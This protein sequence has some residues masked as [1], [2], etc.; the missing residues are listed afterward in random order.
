MIFQM[1]LLR[2]SGI[3]NTTIFEDNNNYITNN[4]F[5]FKNKIDDFNDEITT[6]RWT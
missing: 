4:N 6:T 2:W 3:T 1:I 5:M